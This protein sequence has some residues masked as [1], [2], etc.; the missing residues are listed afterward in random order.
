MPDKAGSGPSPLERLVAARKAEQK[1]QRTKDSR[2]LAAIGLAAVVVIGGGVFAFAHFAPQSWRNQAAA[3]VKSSASGRPS[4]AASPAVK[5]TTQPLSPVDADGPPGDPFSGTPADRWADGAAGITIPAARAHGSYSAAQVRSAFEITRKLLVAGNLDWP[6]LRGGKPTAFA[7]LLTKGQRVTFLAGLRTR[8]LN[9]DGTQRNTRTWVTS[10]APGST[11]FVTTVIKVHGTMSARAAS[12]F[13]TPVLR[14]RFDYFFVFAVEPPG[15]PARWMRIVQQQYDTVDFASWDKPD[16]PLEPWV[17]G[18]G[19]GTAGVRCSTQDGY[20]HPDYSQ[21]RSVD[22]P[23]SGAPQDPY[24]S[25]TPSTGP[26]ES[27]RTVTGT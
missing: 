26:A 21:G 4:S 9:K 25:D 16:G 22:Q 7:D 10:F 11:E 8:A 18:T 13:R 14:V 3:L 5:L 15:D 12:E 2:V 19:V 17:Y 20:F 27:C 24:A 6:T 1:V 23:A